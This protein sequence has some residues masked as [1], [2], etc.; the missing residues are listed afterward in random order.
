MP[1]LPARMRH[2]RVLIVFAFLCQEPPALSRLKYPSFP[3][4]NLASSATGTQRLKFSSAQPP[5]PSQPLLTSAAFSC[6][7]PHFGQLSQGG[8]CKCDLIPIE[9]KPLWN[10]VAF[11]KTRL[12]LIACLFFLT[13]THQETRL[14][15]IRNRPLAGSRATEA[16]SLETLLSTLRKSSIC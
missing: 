14:S 11:A 7:K 15:A 2:D 9:N 1:T 5:H 16:I 8:L 12:E 3:Y 10:K 13:R 4:C 6:P